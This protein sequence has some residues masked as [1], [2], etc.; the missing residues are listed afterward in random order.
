RTQ[1]REPVLVNCTGEHR[2][3]AAGYRVAATAYQEPMMLR[4]TEVSTTHVV[5]MGVSGS[6]KSTVATG[7]VR[8]TGYAFAE[9]D[10]FHPPANVAKMAAGH[11]LVDE[12]RWPWLRALADWTAARQQEGV[13]TVMACSALRR[14]YR[15]VLRTGAPET[16]FVHV[17]GAASVI[18]KRMNHRDGHFMPASLLESQIATLEPLEPDEHGV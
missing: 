6:G 16:S 10:E 15:D 18:R 4:G 14:S 13:S 2:V 17:D 8:A 12:D 9:A 1:D 7:L 5:V 11:A 3:R